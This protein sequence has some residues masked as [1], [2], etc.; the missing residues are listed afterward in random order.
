MKKLIALFLYCALPAAHAVEKTPAPPTLQDFGWRQSL[1]IPGQAS[2]YRFALPASVYAGSR[3]ADLGDLRVFNGNGELVPYAF[4]PRRAPADAPPQYVRL[5]RFPVYATSGADGNMR[6]ALRADK[7]GRLSA[8]HVESGGKRTATAPVM[9]A[10]ILDASALKQPI[11]ALKLA[12]QAKDGIASVNLEASDNLQDW[13]PLL[14]QAQLVDLRV[15]EERL[16]KNRI[17]LGGVRSK[18]L[19]LSWAGENAVDI[20]GA[21]AEIRVG[22]AA[23]APMQ[24]TKT[25]SVQVGAS[26]GEYLFENSGLP[27]TGL[28]I[29]LPQP[30]TVVALRVSHRDSNKSPW[31]DAGGATVYR[32][33]HQ[34][35]EL[36]S[37]DLSIHPSRDRHWR[38]VVDIR[39]GGLGPGMPDIAFGWTPQEVL[40]VARGNP[41]FTLAYGNTE[42]TPAGYAAASLLPGYTEEQLANLPQAYAG[43]I[44]A[45]HG[46]ED[47]SPSV[48]PATRHKL[49]LW[50]VLLVG[51]AVLGLMVWRLMRQMNES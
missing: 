36:V 40:F 44:V 15:G 5:P 48:D 24:W 8:L 39:G 9:R 1:E 16:L 3:R 37:P 33:T 49:A 38:I 27:V 25:G 21:E 32:M 6:I 41:P 11:A 7:D 51:V 30:N 14:G 13:R 12:W 28:S 43:M 34:G 10:W 18:Y 42:I 22:A 17:E 47:A 4:L 45:P 50:A 20:S 29:A 31:R 23:P 26:A 46:T 19:R 35:Q 2:A